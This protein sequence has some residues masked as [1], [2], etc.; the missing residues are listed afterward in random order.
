[1]LA[2]MMKYKELLYFL[3]HKEVRI[4][5][6]NSFFGF[7]W[8]L[9]E[10]LGLMVIYTIVFS[11]ISGNRWKRGRE[12]RTLPPVHPFRT[13]TLDLF[14]QCGEGGNQSVVQQFL[15]H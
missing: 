3:V 2:E 1:M 9:L 8:S 11:L 10:P 14:Q 13:H 15:P 7:F 4:K 5:Y 12:D 6:R